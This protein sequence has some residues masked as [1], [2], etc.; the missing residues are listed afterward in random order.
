[1]EVIIFVF[2]YNSIGRN[3][4]GMILYIT[5]PICNGKFLKIVKVYF[6]TKFM[7]RRASHDFHFP[8]VAIGRETGFVVRNDGKRPHDSGGS[9]KQSFPLLV[10]FPLWLFMS[11]V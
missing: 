9:D 8:A 7:P 3:W 5:K 2:E 6:K 1:M 4:E 11:N 10:C